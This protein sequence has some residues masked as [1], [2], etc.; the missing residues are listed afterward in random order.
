[1]ATRHIEVQADF[2]FAAHYEA[3]RKIGGTDARYR[4]FRG[5]GPRL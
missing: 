5:I 3:A 2:D 1:M 4:R